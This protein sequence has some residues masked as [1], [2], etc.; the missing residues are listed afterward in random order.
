MEVRVGVGVIIINDGLVLVG[1]R[2]NSHGEGCWQFPG[3]HIDFGETVEAA[4]AREVLE[5]TGLRVTNLRRGPYTNDVF[6]EEGKHYI[7]LF[8]LADYAGGQVVVKE[9]DKCEGWQ[10]V[11]WEKIPRPLFLPMQNLMAQ[12]YRPAETCK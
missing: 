1:K 7:T 9:P 3:G 2:R 4:A 10:W 12:G 5:E 11:E 6:R 8:I